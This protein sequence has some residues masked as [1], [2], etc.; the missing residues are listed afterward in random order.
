MFT[1]IFKSFEYIGNNCKLCN[2]LITQ[3]QN[4]DNAPLRCSFITI[5]IYQMI[6]F[7]L[8]SIFIITFVFSVSRLKGKIITF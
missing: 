6:D 7:C 4:H 5:H 8:G 3:R 2:F 1:L